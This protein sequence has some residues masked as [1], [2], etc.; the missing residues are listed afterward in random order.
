ML[1]GGHAYTV[2]RS[3]TLGDG[4]RALVIRNPWATD[5]GSIASGRRDDGYLTLT[6]P[7]L[8]AATLAFSTARV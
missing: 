8:H 4:T 2:V 1:V 6:A 3:A 5:G 7:Q